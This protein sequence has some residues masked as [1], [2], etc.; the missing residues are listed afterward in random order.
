MYVCAQFP[1]PAQLSLACCA[2]CPLPAMCDK[3]PPRVYARLGRLPLHRRMVSNTEFL[4]EKEAMKAEALQ[5][6]QEKQK[7]AEAKKAMKVAQKS[8]ITTFMKPKK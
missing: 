1:K 4:A 6:A 8:K 5:K 3:T 7:K 2:P